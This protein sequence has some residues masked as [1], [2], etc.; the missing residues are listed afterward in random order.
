[1]EYLVYFLIYLL[2]FPAFVLLIHFARLFRDTSRENFDRS[3]IVDFQK[4]ITREFIFLIES[5]KNSEMGLACLFLFSILGYVWTLLG[6]SIGSPHYT[7]ELGNYFFLSFALP[8]V[9]AF[10]YPYILEGF[11]YNYI[12]NK[13][14]SFVSKFLKQQNTILAGVSISMVAA[15]MT[16]YGYH[17]RIYFFFVLL[18][19]VSIIG[20]FLYRYLFQK[21]SSVFDDES[22]DAEE[23]SV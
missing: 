12:K 17:H 18:N 3:E 15:N 2:T 14:D 20:I 4:N 5:N 11:F 13:P 10:G 1:M 23:L 6:G 21:P 22:D 19:S 8:A 16:V 9:L 7:N